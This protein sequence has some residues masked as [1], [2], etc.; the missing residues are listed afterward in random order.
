[1]NGG[2]D[3][4]YQSYAYVVLSSVATYAVNAAE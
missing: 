1:M 3:V 4:S 2:I